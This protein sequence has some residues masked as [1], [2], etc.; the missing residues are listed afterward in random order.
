MARF[1]QC[2]PDLTNIFVKFGNHAI[3]SDPS[4]ANPFFGDGCG[5][6]LKMP[7]AL[8]NEV[9]VFK[10]ILA[11]VGHIDFFAGIHVPVFLKGDKTGVGMAQTKPE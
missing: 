3:V 7:H 9:E 8:I 10:V 5:H 2:I 1:F 4:S 6:A 11:H